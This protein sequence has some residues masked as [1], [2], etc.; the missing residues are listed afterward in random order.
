MSKVNEINVTATV[1]L[2][3]ECA[4][5]QAE[6][7]F[8][9]QVKEHISKR[10]MADYEWLAFLLAYNGSVR[11]FED[12]KINGEK[13]D[14]AVGEWVPKVSVKFKS[15]SDMKPISIIERI[16][17]RYEILEQMYYH[18]FTTVENPMPSPKL[19]DLTIEYN[20]AVGHLVEVGFIKNV[21]NEL[22]L[23]VKGIEEVE[24]RHIESIQSPAAN[25]SK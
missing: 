16:K 6:E 2:T 5:E 14:F 21:E 23:T 24:R 1:V 4:L 22:Y 20:R 25:I 3:K 19:T 7:K 15:Y 10:Q 18:H 9:E 8:A 12:F 13:A 17:L 11:T